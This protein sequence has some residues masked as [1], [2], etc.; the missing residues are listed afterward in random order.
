MKKI[1]FTLALVMGISANAFAQQQA[2][3]Y[4]GPSAVSAITVAEALKLG[5]DKQVILVGKIEKSLGNEK[6][7]FTDNTGSVTVE[8]DD[9]EWRGLTLNEND[10][11]EIKGEI[12]KD[13]T[14]F[15]VDVDSITKK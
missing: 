14:S 10:I 12:D 8:I 6:Y 13:F 3:G 4:T 1:A 5:D 15:E 7:T 11:V 2:G 9:D